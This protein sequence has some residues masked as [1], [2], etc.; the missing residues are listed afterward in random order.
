MELT[1]NGNVFENNNFRWSTT[2]TFSFN[3]RKIKRLYG[4]MEKIKDE[5]GNIIGEKESDDIKNKWFIGHD[6]DQLWDYEGAGV[7]QIGEEK[8]A[9]RYGNKPGDFKYLDLNDDG[10]LND[11]DKVFQGYTT[12]RFRWSWRNDFTFFN[13]FICSFMLYSHVGQYGTF[14]RAA[15]T[16]GMYDRY[17]IVDIPRWTEDNPINDYARLGSRNLG[18]HYVKKSFVRMENI[19]VSYNVPKKFL[20]KISVQN[21]R[22]SLSVRNPFVISKW[23]FGDPEG[24]DTTMKSYTLG[25]NFTL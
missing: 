6:P 21:F 3:R 17:T 4:D 25:V 18:N 24:G 14:N 13:D 12:P 15:N 11:D 7:W 23:N 9:S 16:G 22:V 10:V 2:G 19:S 8:E 20:Q 1:L 5:E